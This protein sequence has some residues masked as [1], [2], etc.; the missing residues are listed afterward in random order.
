MN[1]GRLRFE[2]LGRVRAYRGDEELDLGHVRQQAVLALLLLHAGRPV[3]LA[4]IVHTLWNGDPPENGDDIV[5]RYIGTLRRILDPQRTALLAHTDDGYVLRTG[6]NAVDTGVFRAALDRAR[7]EHQ[8]GTH[9]DGTQEVRAVL[10]R[11]Q[12]EPLSG[13]TGPYF[14]SAR[15]RLKEERATAS[16]LLAKPIL[17]T[18]AA[19]APATTPAATPAPDHAEPVDP[20]AGHDLFPP[21][22]ST[23]P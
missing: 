12:E 3:P 4:Q 18:P 15:A 23:L 8:T 6:D 5:L 9:G 11:W 21:D 17:A 2:I 20:W 16:Q 10:D 22:W 13:L 14:E 19:T 1:D 7:S